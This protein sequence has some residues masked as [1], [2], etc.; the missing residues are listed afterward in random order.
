MGGRGEW[1][2]GLDPRLVTRA[3]DCLGDSHERR[4]RGIES[5]IG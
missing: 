3:P 5:D 1:L 2:G 4:A